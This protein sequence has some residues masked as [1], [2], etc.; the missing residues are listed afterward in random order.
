MGPLPEETLKRLAEFDT[1][2]ICNAVEDLETRDP[3]EGYMG[4][5]VKCMFPELGRMVGYAVTATGRSTVP[6]KPP[7][8][9]GFAQWYEL[10]E[11]SP[12]PAVLVLKDVGHDRHR[13][14]HFGDVMGTIS[15]KL[16]ALGLVTDGGVRDIETVKEMGFRYFAAGAVPAHG[17]P[18][19][20]SAGLDVTISGAHVRTGDLI[21]AD[22]NGVCVFPPEIA[23]RVIAR[24]EEVLEI[25]EKRRATITTPGF[26]AADLRNLP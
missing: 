26:K 14:C 25:E 21:H 16:G 3:T 22:E 13:S 7:K 6:G 5:D 9:D 2:T 18:E 8:G 10:V 19:I 12:R 11:E 1:P 15:V 4:L 20:V 23:D 24:A 17:F